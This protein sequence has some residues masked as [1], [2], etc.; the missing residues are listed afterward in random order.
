MEN[1]EKRIKIKRNK[2]SS[3]LQKV[4][5]KRKKKLLVTKKNIKKNS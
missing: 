3:K 2:L 5:K 1:K 4:F